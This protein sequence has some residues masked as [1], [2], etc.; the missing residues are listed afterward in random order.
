[1]LNVEKPPGSQKRQRQFLL[2]KGA[3]TIG[4]QNRIKTISELRQL[5]QDAVE[6]EHSTIPPY[7]CALYSIQE[8]TNQGAAQTIKSVVI[9]EMLHMVLAANVLN[10]VGGKP[11]INHKGFVPKY[12]TK[13][14]VIQADFVVNLGR[15]SQSAIE[16][17]I[18]IERPRR[19]QGQPLGC[20]C[21]HD[22]CTIGQFYEAVELG[23]KDLSEVENIFTGPD[24]R[25]ITAEHY[26]GAGGK[27]LPVSDLES[28]MQAL[29]EI[30]GQGEGINSTVWDGDIEFGDEVAEVAHYFRFKEILV[31]RRYQQGDKINLPPTGDCFDVSW[32][33][34]YPMQLNPKM[35][36]LPI[37]SG[38]WQKSAAFN[39]VYG[40]LLD[41]LDAAC[42]GK[43]ERM[44]ESVPIM[45][46]LKYRAVELM[47]IPVAGTD[48][49][50]GPSFEFLRAPQ[51]AIPN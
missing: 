21:I 36:D 12:P 35:A 5:L 47:Q 9:E 50:I 30:V 44:M 11:S 29:Q 32:D 8:G 3:P 34:V 37:N 27:V 51:D 22:F 19:P 45:Y 41:T 20:K 17:F 14:P 13:L 10:A 38:V 39:Q 6:L 43:P 26:Y 28:A 7:L 18:E 23:L 25:Q 49:T 2:R 4:P 1:M 42:N 48:R 15:F 46:E 16:T 24:E 31:G 40:N 33:N